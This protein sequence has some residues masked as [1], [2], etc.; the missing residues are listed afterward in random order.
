MGLSS[1]QEFKALMRALND[2]VA[3]EKYVNR[4][5]LNALIPKPTSD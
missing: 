1:L 2:P 4:D 3:L 5:I